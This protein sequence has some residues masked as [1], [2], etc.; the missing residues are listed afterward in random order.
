MRDNITRLIWLVTDQGMFALGNFVLNVQ[1]ARYL[2]PHDYG[3]F[4][5]S[6]TAFMFL[7]VIYYGGLLEALLVLSGRVQA[8]R[9]R[10]YLMALLRLH[11]LLFGSAIALCALASMGA[12]GLGNSEAGWLI[13]GAAIGG[14]ANLALLTVRR[15]CLIFLSTRISAQIGIVYVVGVNLTSYISIQLWTVSWFAMWEI[16]GGWS[17]IC[18]ALVFKLLANRLTGRQP[19]SLLEIL[20]FQAGYA[21]FTLVA[22]VGMW[23]TAESIMIFLVRIRG[24]EA[25]AETRI[26]FNLGSPLVQITIAMN[27][28]WLVEFSAK[29]ANRERHGVAGQALPYIA[30][31][32]LAAIICKVAGFQVMDF[33][34][35]GKDRRSS[36][37]SCQSIASGSVWLA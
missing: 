27:T 25:V 1:F 34:Y 8:D 29:H 13:M 20:R 32:A 30:V 2:S 26:I 3:L 22:A 24:L 36:P 18:A 7:S 6:F 9:R 37:G 12:C 31:C 19:F 35:R 23:I 33:L 10:S 11:L 17:L 15:L 14:S 4:A 16:I 21:P 5:I 28:F